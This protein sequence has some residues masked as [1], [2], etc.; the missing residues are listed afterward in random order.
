MMEVFEESKKDCMDHPTPP[1]PEECHKAE[2]V[3]EDTL[4]GLIASV[5]DQYQE[6]TMHFAAELE[7]RV[8]WIE[9]ACQL[10]DMCKSDWD[11]IGHVSHGIYDEAKRDNWE[12]V[13]A[14]AKFIVE[15][16]KTDV[17]TDCNHNNKQYYDV[18]TERMG[19]L[20]ECMDDIKGVVAAA[21]DILK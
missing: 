12:T 13:D 5:E 10:H 20:N 3:M 21:E 11:R 19:G 17:H 1:S 15:I 8:F 4:Q 18:V 7:H 14:A 6:G 16:I 9:R 2:W